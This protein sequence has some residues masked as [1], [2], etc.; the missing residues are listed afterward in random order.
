[1]NPASSDDVVVSVATT[2][3]NHEAY[4][5]EAIE[6]VLRQET[7]FAVELVIGED[8]S[9]DG[10]RA[11]VQAYAERF[12]GRIRLLLAERNQGLTA[13]HCAVLD[14]CTGKYVALLDGDDYWVDPTKLQRQVAMLE[15]DPELAI[16]FHNVL[17]L[18]ENQPSQP[19]L[20]CPESQKELSTL[21]DILRYN[22]IPAC[23]CVFRRGLYGKLPHWY[24]TLPWVD[25]P[26]HI[27]NA[28][29]GDIGYINAVMAVYRLHSSNVSRTQ[30]HPKLIAEGRIRMFRALDKELDRRY[31]VLLKQQIARSYYKK[32]A[33]E[34]REGA[35]LSAL[36]SL[37]LSAAMSLGSPPAPY[38][39]LLGRVLRS[40]LGS[41]PAAPPVKASLA[42]SDR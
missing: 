41:R 16:C 25:W 4:I 9:T 21:E 6:S 39:T 18:R 24:H 26:L 5:A 12:P 33:I 27:L 10:T 19:R 34:R 14:A 17:V 1:M 11:I 7:D 42:D 22:F 20:F 13:N 3:Y 32:A 36:R 38:R 29:H 23:S 40:G 30:W 2:T 35:H 31:H 28:R 8:C 37:T 15:S